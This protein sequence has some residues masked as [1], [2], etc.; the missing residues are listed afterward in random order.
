MTNSPSGATRVTK[1]RL[2]VSGALEEL[3]DFV[4]A[5]E[6]Y[7][8]L[9]EQ[10]HKVSLATVYRILQSMADDGAV[11]VL[12]SGDGEAVYRQCAVE[13]H[14]HH[15][16]CRSCGTAVEIEAPSIETWT[17]QIAAEHGFTAPGHTIEIFGLCPD[18]TA[19]AGAS[20][21]D[22]PAQT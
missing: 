17:R 14:H 16:V 18:C 9:H 4:S 10:G 2:A 19:A 21:E 22:H 12:R 3:T 11:D 8:W 1:Q 20:T 13:A 6:L 15:I 7:R 5:Q